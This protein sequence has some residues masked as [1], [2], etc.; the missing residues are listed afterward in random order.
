LATG[1]YPLQVAFTK[2]VALVGACAE[3]TV[4][5]AAADGPQTIAGYED[6]RAGTVIVEGGGGALLTDLTLRGERTGLSVLD[7]RRGV[8]VRGVVV[9][10]P[11]TQ[12]ISIERSGGVSKLESVVVRGVRPAEDGTVVGI[13]VLTTVGVTLD[14]V[15]VEDVGGPGID[16]RTT[17]EDLPAQAVVEDSVVTRCDPGILAFGH[18]AVDVRR[19]LLAENGAGGIWTRPVEAMAADIAAEDLVVRGS[20]W[21]EGVGIACGLEV[22]HGSR[23]DARRLILED[24]EGGGLCG[25]TRAPGMRSEIS[26]EDLVVRGTSS[27]GR[28]VATAV[29]ALGELELTLRRALLL[30]NQGVGLVVGSLDSGRPP[31]LTVEDLWLRGGTPVPGGHGT[32]GLQAFD[33]ARVGV[34]RLRAQDQAYVA[35]LT[36]GWEEERQTR[37]RLRHVDVD[38]VESVC[39]EE[40]VVEGGPCVDERGR[41]SGGGIGLAAMYG[42]DLGVEGF[43][44]RNAGLAG[45]LVGEGAEL[46]G[47]RGLV[48]GCAIGLNALDEGGAPARWLEDV[49]VY[50]NGLDVAQQE[51]ALP[52]PGTLGGGFA[53]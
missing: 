52:D 50:G 40:G 9:D 35:V 28:P 18:P 33:G 47:K 5:S 3:R 31:E 39:A 37:V 43:R 15:V 8:T 16:V 19:T 23:L 36:Y 27:A 11:R 6:P 22:K 1:T 24:N 53:Q 7:A 45:L 13:R 20:I 44:V 21:H 42:A 30:D 49:F 10:R 26:V 25:Y 2:A 32:G 41:Q 51:V 17:Q 46:R 38:G 14:G 48:T 29:M 34:E 12:G 4:L